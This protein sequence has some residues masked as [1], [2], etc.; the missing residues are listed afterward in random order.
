MEKC[1]PAESF[2]PLE[3]LDIKEIFHRIL[4]KRKMFASG[5]LNHPQEAG[6]IKNY[7]NIPIRV[8][9]HTPPPNSNLRS[10][11]QG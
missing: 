1:A 7:S 5:E 4:M 3:K 6:Y 8:F 10:T 11:T 2:F 9:R